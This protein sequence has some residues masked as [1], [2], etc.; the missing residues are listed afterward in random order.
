MFLFI[1]VN[2]DRVR[3]LQ[4]PK[5][6]RVWPIDGS[7][8]SLSHNTNVEPQLPY[9]RVPSSLSRWLRVWLP[10]CTTGRVESLRPFLTRLGLFPP[11]RNPE[12]APIRMEELRALVRKWNL[13]HKRNFWRENPTK[14][15]VVAALNQHIKHMKVVHDNIEHKKAERRE[16]DRKRQVQHT[17]GEGISPSRTVTSSKRKPPLENTSETC[18]YR[19]GLP[20]H[21]LDWPADAGFPTDSIETG[22]IY[23]SR[24]GHENAKGD[25]SIQRVENVALQEDLAGNSTP[26]RHSET[27]G[28]DGDNDLRGAKNN[29]SKMQAQQKCSV[30]LVNMT[31][32]DQVPESLLNLSEHDC[33]FG[34]CSPGYLQCDANSVVTAVIHLVY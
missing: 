10:P 28:D 26:P 21:R 25:E 22:M 13:H 16:A 27:A 19:D 17:A 12:S 7:Q 33:Y 31:M 2:Q 23:M 29:A 20:L 1:N 5:V 18:L 15:D 8:C 30:A 24:W 11:R 6:A 3:L 14:D 4:R 32:R 34:L 9:D